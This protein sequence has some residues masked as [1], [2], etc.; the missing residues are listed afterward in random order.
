MHAWQADLDVLPDF[1]RFLSADEVARA[2]RFRTGL[3]R[4]RFAAGRGLLRSLLGRYLHLDPAS[5]QFSYGPSGKPMLSG[6]PRLRFN[7]SN[8]EGLALVAIAR[9]IEIGVDVE[10][11]R[12]VPEMEHIAA[13]F[14]APNESATLMALSPDQREAAFF[15]CWTRKE[16]IVK[17]LGEG[18]SHPLDSFEVSFAPGEIARVVSAV[19]ADL[20]AWWLGNLEPAPGYTGAIALQRPVDKLWTFSWRENLAAGE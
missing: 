12:L 3:L 6:A 11:I 2:D 9:D 7:L 16:A 17:C 13:Q 15:A 18:L 8:C 4:Q 5:L 20:L 10:R 14:F 1:E 19:N